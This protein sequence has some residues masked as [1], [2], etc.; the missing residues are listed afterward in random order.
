MLFS[1]ASGIFSMYTF[2]NFTATVAANLGGRSSRERLATEWAAL[3][4]LNGARTIAILKSD[5][6]AMKL[7]FSGD[8]ERTS[9][10]ISEIQK[11]L[12]KTDSSTEA[13]RLLN[14]IGTRREAYTSSRKQAL[15]AK[16][17][18]VDAEL[19]RKVDEVVVPAM[20]AYVAS[21]AELATY[22]KK[23]LD[24]LVPRLESEAGHTRSILLALL[25]GSILVS[26]V[27]AWLI[28][29]G[30]TRSLA[31]AITT[32]DRLAAGDLTFEVAR[33]SSDETGKLLSSMGQILGKLTPI[34]SSVKYA[35]LQME[36]SSFQ[37][38]KISN[39]IGAANSAQ[40][41][42]FQAVSEAAGEVRASSDSVRQ[43]AE[44]VREKSVKTE[45]EA[46]RG[47]RAVRE[48]I[49]QMQ[50]TVGDVGRAA[51]ETT[52]LHQVGEQ[53]H[54]IIESISDI[55]DQTNL[56]ALNAAIEA[57][58]AGE[59][60]RGF[61]VVADEV[62]NLA[63]RTARETEEI[64]RIISAFAC[65]VDTNRQTMEQV[66]CQVNEG[67]GKSRETAQVIDRMVASV[68]ESAV[69]NLQISEVSVSQMERLGLLRDSLDSLFSTIRENGAKVGV[70]STIS[71]DLN[72][73]STQINQQMTN[74][75]FN[76]QADA[77]LGDHEKRRHPRLRNGMLAFIYQDGKKLDAEGITEDLSLSGVKLR[78]PVGSEE[79]SASLLTL[80]IML[81]CASMDGFQSQPP[82]RVDVKVVRRSQEGSNNVLGLEFQNLA[83]DQKERLEACF[84]HFNKEA[85]YQKS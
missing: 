34:L 11:E 57:A 14:E 10:R 3:V 67:E 39:E 55:A 79:T 52:K 5:G 38:S 44:S 73:I 61:A 26:V 4:N 7:A 21:I 62:R 83:R 13:K 43:L 15:Q 69:S 2:G 46:E 85:R 22:N 9:Q 40:Q 65:Q 54:R 63:S 8:L 47:L 49:A 35:S 25:L 56:L 31:Q 37:I 24:R 16:S 36:Q 77:R 23:A 66:V 84:E 1:A 68:R 19:N 42:R 64:T 74:F 59:Q 53:I 45:A 48:N 28:I 76:R 51:A 78:L 32:A 80:E 72:L 71:S 60:G 18:L 12:E 30:I 75:T 17:D 33:G 70:T 29:R 6:A 41:D 27:A 50:K 20:A 58:R 81:P 82:L